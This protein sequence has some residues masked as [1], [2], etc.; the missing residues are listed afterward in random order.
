VPKEEKNQRIA[1]YWSKLY[2]SL[3]AETKTTPGKVNLVTVIVLCGFWIFSFLA[4]LAE[5]AFDLQIKT[6][7][8]ELSVGGNPGPIGITALV[9]LVVWLSVTFVCV[10]V[11]IEN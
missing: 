4:L 11:Y 10:N 9:M 2:K 3:L 6:A 8:F 5:M 1:R 7:W